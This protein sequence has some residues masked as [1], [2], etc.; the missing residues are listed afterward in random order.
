MAIRK[1]DAEMELKFHPQ[2]VERAVRAPVETP[3]AEG[4]AAAAA[5]P[6]HRMSAH[7]YTHP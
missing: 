4:R 7:G 6:A 1:H 5:A 3:P 2:K